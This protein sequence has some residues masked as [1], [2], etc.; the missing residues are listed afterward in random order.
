MKIVYKGIIRELKKKELEVE[1][2]IFN[3]CLKITKKEVKS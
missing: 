2:E 1:E 3:E